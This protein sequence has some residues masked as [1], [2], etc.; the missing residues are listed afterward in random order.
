MQQAK[1]VSS[2]MTTGEKLVNYCSDPAEDT[3]L[4]RRVV[5]ALQYATITRLEIA[6]SVN[7]VCQFMQQ[8]LQVHQKAVKRI[9]RYLSGTLDFGLH[10]HTVSG[11]ALN[12]TA[13]CD[14]DWA[15][16]LDGMR[17]ASV[18]CVYFGSNLISWSSKIQH[19]ISRLSTKAEY[20]SL[21]SLVAEITWIQSLLSELQVPVSKTPV[22]WCDNLSAVLLSANPMLHA[23]TKH[24]EI[25]RSLL[26]SREGLEETNRSSSYASC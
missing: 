5:G 22:I 11:N 10:L 21:A 12:I 24:I 13:Y 6:Y 8:P 20:R 15:L 18:F 3:Q 9:L 19:T 1:R 16:Y 25:D 17:S 26:Y 2:P 14:S 4:Y 23:H 7:K